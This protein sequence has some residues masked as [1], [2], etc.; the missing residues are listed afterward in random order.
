[1]VGLMTLSAHNGLKNHS[2][3][4]PQLAIHPGNP[5]FSYSMATARIS[6][7]KFVNSHSIITSTC[8]VFLHIRLTS[9]NLSML[10]ASAPCRMPG[11]SAAMKL[12]LR[13]VRTYLEKI[14]S[15]NI[16]QFETKYFHGQLSLKR[17]GSIVA[18]IPLIQTYSK[19]RIL[20]RVRQHQSTCMY[21]H[22]FRSPKRLLN[23]YSMLRRILISRRAW[24]PVLTLMTKVM[25]GRTM[26]S[27]TLS[28]HDK[29]LHWRRHL[30]IPL[31]HRRCAH[32]HHP[33][34]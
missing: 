18:L 31:L 2:Y 28:S 21:F 22:L 1:M 9:C 20:R 6:R 17:H 3:L 13:Q 23:H 14:L 30:L 5:S 26:M 34:T 15:V 12:S 33:I 11:E 27:Q 10:V 24:S 7:I 4:R 25:K 19:K 16:W 29:N 8:S 32:L